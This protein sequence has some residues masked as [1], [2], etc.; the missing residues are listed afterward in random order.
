MNEPLWTICVEGHDKGAQ[1]RIVFNT[2]KHWRGPVVQVHVF[3]TL[4]HATRIAASL[5]FQ[6]TAEEAGDAY[7]LEEMEVFPPLDFQETSPLTHERA[8]QWADWLDDCIGGLWLMDGALDVRLLEDKHLCNI[9]T[10]QE[11]EM[12]LD[13]ALVLLHNQEIVGQW[14][15]ENAVIPA[16]DA[17]ELDPEKPAMNPGR[18]AQL[19]A[20]F[21][22]VHD[23]TWPAIAAEHRRWTDEERAMMASWSDEERRLA[24]LVKQEKTVVIS[25]SVRG[26][27]KNLLAW[28]KARG[29]HAYIGR[30]TR[31]GHPQSPL[32][33]P[34]SVK[35]HGL[36]GALTL[37]RQ[38][39][40][41]RPDLLT[42]V[43]D[44]CGLTLGCWCAPGLCHGDLLAQI[45]NR[46]EVK[47]G[48]SATQVLN[49]MAQDACDCDLI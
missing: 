30:R 22:H 16:L 23:T 17:K 41:S 33:N 37:Y 32:A 26:P 14:C 9:Y 12:F 4:A 13:A 28:S 49:E 45:A 10:P 8:C 38:H 21:H 3:P 42:N 15:Q 39:L 19:R 18:A 34:F 36:N 25:E 40:L 47:Y 20:F 46:S 6:R 48:K 44:L 7:V 43:D 31:Q 5:D 35:K 27:H 1:V 29:S 11:K 24:D 2:I